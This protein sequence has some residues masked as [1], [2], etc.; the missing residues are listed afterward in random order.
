[1]QR[2]YCCNATW[3]PSSKVEESSSWRP[4][5]CAIIRSKL[6]RWKSFSEK[7]KTP[8]EVRSTSSY[9]HSPPATHFINTTSRRSGKGLWGAI[10][11]PQQVPADL[12]IPPS[13]PTVPV[14]APVEDPPA[15]VAAATERDIRLS[16]LLVSRTLRWPSFT[17]RHWNYVLWQLRN[18]ERCCLL[19]RWKSIK[20]I[21]QIAILVEV[22]FHF[23]FPFFFSLQKERCNV[24]W[25]CVGGFSEMT[26]GLIVSFIIRPVFRCHGNV[27]FT[28]LLLEFTTKLMPKWRHRGH[29]SLRTI[30]FPPSY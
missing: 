26:Q 20:T 29:E 25:S 9:T 17:K 21:T 6:W 28:S 14:P 18:F 10:Q 5:G 19:L 3:S 27:T 7:P 8:K 12:S 1:M 23:S 22:L 30:S 24:T 4:S 13:S 2:W 11:P 16:Y 15:E